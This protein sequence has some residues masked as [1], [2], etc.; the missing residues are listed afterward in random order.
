M[1]KI[2]SIQYAGYPGL[3]NIYFLQHPD[4]HCDDIIKVVYWLECILCLRA[5]HTAENECPPIR[6]TAKIVSTKLLLQTLYGITLTCELCFQGVTFST[7][8]RL[9]FRLDKHDSESGVYADIDR[10]ERTYMGGSTNTSGGLKMILS[11]VFSTSIPINLIFILSRISMACVTEYMTLIVMGNPI[12]VIFCQYP[13]L[14][15]KNQWV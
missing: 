14:Y 11:E 12:L 6:Q 2:L 1:Q 3:L 7:I 8:A 15:Q 9:F 4:N 13:A 10:I 5:F